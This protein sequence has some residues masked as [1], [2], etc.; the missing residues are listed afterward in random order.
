MRNMASGHDK[1][2]VADLR[3]SS[4][5]PRAPVDRHMFTERIIVTDVEPSLLA[6]KFLVLRVGT[7]NNTRIGSIALAQRRPLH[8]AHVVHQAGPS[9]DGDFRTDDAVRTNRYVHSD[10]RRRMY[11]GAGVN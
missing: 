1:A 7:Q 2:L 4:S 3:L 5:Q 6:Y 9:A 11:D 8:D 10:L